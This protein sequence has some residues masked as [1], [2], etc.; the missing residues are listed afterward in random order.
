MKQQR[1]KELNELYKMPI[2]KLTKIKRNMLK[3]VLKRVLLHPFRIA[4]SVYL[5]IILSIVI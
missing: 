2:G 3:S 1:I 4:S 5:L